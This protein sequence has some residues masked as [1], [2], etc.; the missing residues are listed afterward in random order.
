MPARKPI[1]PAGMAP[2]V[3]TAFIAGQPV[4]EP[5]PAA[6]EPRVRFTVDLPRSLH[7]RLQLAAVE[8]SEKMTVLAREALAAWLDSQ[9]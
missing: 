1:I 6:D 9:S 7:K 5:V 3:A 2:E 8:R 4:T